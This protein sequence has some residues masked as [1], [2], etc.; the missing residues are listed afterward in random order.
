MIHIR[1]IVTSPDVSHE[2]AVALRPAAR[3]ELLAHAR[4]LRG[5][6]V[7]VGPVGEL[8]EVLARR[9]V[10]QLETCRGSTGIA[11]VHEVG[12]PVVELE[13]VP[14]RALPGV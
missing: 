2:T 10:W 9:D 5:L 6:S 8:G 4:I 14:I 11:P 1:V 13:V 3:E 12:R 7:E